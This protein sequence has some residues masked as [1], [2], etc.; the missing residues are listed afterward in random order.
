MPPPTPI[1]ELE[2]CVNRL[3]ETSGDEIWDREKVRIAHQL[4]I[5]FQN[6]YPTQEDYDATK[7]MLLE[8]AELEYYR[9]HE[10][11]ATSPAAQP[12]GSEAGGTSPIQR[13]VADNGAELDARVSPLAVQLATGGR[14]TTPK[15][16]V[17]RAR[18]EFE[19]AT[20]ALE[21]GWPHLQCPNCMAI[22]LSP[23]ET[24]EPTMEVVLDSGTAKLRCGRC[25]FHGAGWTLAYDKNGDLIQ[26]I[27]DRD[28]AGFSVTSLAHASVMHRERKRAELESLEASE[29]CVTPPAS[30]VPTSALAAATSPAGVSS[31]SDVDRKRMRIRVS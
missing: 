3:L 8:Q 2:V 16:E 20:Q 31:T 29:R 13:Q 5:R 4:L 19:R 18:G 26:S 11:G 22:E 6:S 15:H 30:A 28:L 27:K 10:D 21:C 9:R 23:L 7:A 14:G 17:G 12:A 1:T 25:D 24:W